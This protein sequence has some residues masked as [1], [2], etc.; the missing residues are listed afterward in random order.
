MGCTARFDDNFKMIKR[1]GTIV[2]FGNASGPVQ[3]VALSKLTE[4]NVKLLRPMWVPC[5]SHML[6]TA[7]RPCHVAS[8]Y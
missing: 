3:P 8:G 6:L 7:L 5:V 2:S 1:K 4:K